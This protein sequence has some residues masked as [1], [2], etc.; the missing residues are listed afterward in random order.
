MFNSTLL[1][2][3]RL[4]HFCMCFKEGWEKYAMLR[5]QEFAWVP[6]RLNGCI[7]IASVLVPYR[8]VYYLLT[9]SANIQ[10]KN[11]TE[12]WSTRSKINSGT[13]QQTYPCNEEVSESL[14]PATTEFATQSKF[15]D[16]TR[17]VSRITSYSTFLQRKLIGHM[18]YLGCSQNTLMN[19]WPMT[20]PSYRIFIRALRWKVKLIILECLSMHLKFGR[21]F[22]FDGG[23]L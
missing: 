13:C 2:F 22:K 12:C 23:S 5:I 7:L 15:S 20:D 16:G 14:L 10:G 18:E 9:R 21:H 1:F 6:S 8:I 3:L 17:A 4:F 11:V 19:K